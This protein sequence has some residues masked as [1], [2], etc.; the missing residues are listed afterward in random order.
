MLSLLILAAASAAMAAPK[1]AERWNY[2]GANLSS[3][4]GVDTFLKVLQQSK[5][6]GCTHILMPEGGYF[7]LPDNPAYLKRVAKVKEKA[8]ELNLVLVPTVYSLGYSGRYLGSDPNLAAGL[9]VKDEPFTV[10]GKTAQVDPSLAIDCSGLKP[11]ENGNIDARLKARP[12]TQYSIRFTMKKEFNGDADEMVRISTCSGKRWVTRQHPIMYK[13]GSRLI[14]QTVFNTLELEGG[15]M[16]VQIMMPCEDIQIEP[17][18]MSQIVRR[19]LTPLT[20][21]SED[22]KAV[23]VEGQDFKAV[24]DPVLLTAP[25]WSAAPTMV[26]VP[27]IMGP[28]IELTDGSRIKDRQKLL[29]SFFHA[30]RIYGDQDEISMEDPKVFKLMERDATNCVKVWGTT[31]YFMNYDEIRICGW[32]TMPGGKPMTPGQILAGHVRKGY[33]FIRKNAPDAIVYTW[34]DMFSPFENATGPDDYK[35]TPEGLIKVPHPAMAAPNRY[36]Y[37]VHDFWEGS[38]E[39]L[40][41]DTKIFTWAA[42]NSDDIE[43]FA[44]RGQ[45]QILCGYYDGKTEKQMKNNISRWLKLSEG[46]KGILGFMYTTWGHN[47]KNLMPYFDLLD[48]ADKWMTTGAP[49]TDK[50]EGMPTG[51]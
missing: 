48:T 4:A 32:E 34:S 39:G 13:D 23:Y 30:Y 20:V 17:V 12:Y 22:G 8:R 36:Y 24:K 38:W 35:M 51:G 41:K 10:S 31:G 3:D 21:T 26:A 5:D 14:A 25:D 2:V 49:T 44:Q 37:L 46:Q 40:P 7:N 42:H 45:E 50:V 28:A 16:R 1:Y 6:V 33:D 15:E 27:R 19:E 18:G 47:Y 9:P 11:V 29:V 43:F